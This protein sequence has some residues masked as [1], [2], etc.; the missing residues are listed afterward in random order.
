MGLKLSLYII[1]VRWALCVHIL[2]SKSVNLSPVFANNIAYKTIQ[3][4][5]HYL[6]HCTTQNQ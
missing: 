2:Y 6:C 5:I 3:L 1:D 4:S